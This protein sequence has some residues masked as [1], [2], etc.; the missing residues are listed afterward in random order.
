MRRAAHVEVIQASHDELKEMYALQARYHFRL[1]VVFSCN[2]HGEVRLLGTYSYARPE[3]RVD[4]SHV[5]VL[6]R[7]ARAVLR[8]SRIGGLFFVTPGGVYAALDDGRPPALIAVLQTS[9]PTE[10]STTRRTSESCRT[11][12]TTRSSQAS[13]SAQTNN[14]LLRARNS[15]TDWYRRMRRRFG[16][17]WDSDW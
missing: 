1:A 13:P 16:D 6:R 12:P 14:Y 9:D 17:L 5:P 7:I 15:V 10:A 8:R 2:P 11:T 3:D 4:L